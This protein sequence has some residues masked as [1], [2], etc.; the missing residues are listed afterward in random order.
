MK[1]KVAKDIADM[2][3]HNMLYNSFDLGYKQEEI[4]EF[5]SM[6]FK[7]RFLWE[8]D[9]VILIGDNRQACITTQDFFNCF[10]G[11]NFRG[12]IIMFIAQLVGRK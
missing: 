8:K 4:D 6:A 5:K 11:Y 3:V 2:K 1:F 12:K 7:A 9:F 10:V